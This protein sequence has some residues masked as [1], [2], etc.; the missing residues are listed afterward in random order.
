MANVTIVY[1]DSQ[2][3]ELLRSPSGPVVQDLVQ[4]A[5]RVL[6]AARRGCPVNTGALRASLHIDMVPGGLYPTARIGTNLAYAL[7][8]HEGHGWIFPK[9]ATILRWPS[10]NNSGTGVRRYRGGA[11]AGYTFAHKVRPVKGRPFL[12]EALQAAS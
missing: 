12:L 9:S 2:I 5:N 8:V 3:S 10:V 1:N 4:R 11:T 7:P 6:V